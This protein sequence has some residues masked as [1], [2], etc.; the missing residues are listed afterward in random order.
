M[1]RIMLFVLSIFLITTPLFAQ[2]DLEVTSETDEQFDKAVQVADEKNNSVTSTNQYFEIELKRGTQSPISKKIPFTAVITPKIDSP[3]TQIL[4]NVPT[5]FKFD[6]NNPE[7]VSLKKGETYSY[8]ISIEPDKAG[9]YDISVNVISWQ[10]NTNK[11]NSANY[12]ITIGDSLT[13]QPTDPQYTMLL[14]LMIFGILAGTGLIT[15]LL[16]KSIKMLIKKAK[17]W[18]TPPL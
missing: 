13:I 17:I 6:S 12:N 8:S 11:S 5:V 15:F 16:I 2:E 18:L 10:Y 9:A 7:F 14:L 4:W 1:K 3:K